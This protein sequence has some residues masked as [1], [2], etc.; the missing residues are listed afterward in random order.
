[1]TGAPGD[2]TEAGADAGTTADIVVIVA[3]DTADDAASY[4]A[5]GGASD[6]PAAR[7]RALRVVVR[8][9]LAVFG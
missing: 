8:I 9:V 4:R 3:E 6:D 1:L 7:G 2:C 5:A